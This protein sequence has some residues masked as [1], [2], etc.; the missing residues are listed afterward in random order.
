MNTKS[1]KRLISLHAILTT[2]RD[3]LRKWKD[4]YELLGVF[5][6]VLTSFLAVHESQKAVVLTQETVQ[7]QQQEFK[8]RNRPYLILTNPRFAGK[9]TFTDGVV[10]PDTIAVESRNIAEIPA[11]NIKT[12][13]MLFLD[14]KKF[15]ESVISDSACAKDD[16]RLCG[17]GIPAAFTNMVRSPEHRFEVEIVARYSGMFD[18]TS[19]YETTARIRY[20]PTEGCL[21]QAN[22]TLR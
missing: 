3:H 6:A 16:P 21:K 8:L 2:V 13:G 4:P 19:P 17:F 9:D 22:L 7:L 10:F 18:Q 14:G 5:L 11:I 12:R 20:Y 15:A 1:M